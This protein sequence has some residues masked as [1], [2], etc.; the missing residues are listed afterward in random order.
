MARL[1]YFNVPA[2]GHINPS[3]PMVA[4]LVGRGEQVDYYCYE[5]FRPAIER[6]GARFRGYE[7]GF[8][9]EHV[10][11]DPNF[12]KFAAVLLKGVQ[13]LLPSLLP[14][15]E[16]ARPDYVIHDSLCSWGRYVAQ[17]LKL[18]D[19]CV[20]THFAMSPRVVGV[21]LKQVV[22]MGRMLASALP[23]VR[24]FRRV[25]REL[26]KAYGIPAP[27]ML[28]MYA[29]D[30]ER[31]LVLTSDYF[32]PLA[33]SFHGGYRFVGVTL[34]EQRAEE[35]LELPADR[36]IIYISLGTVFNQDLAFYRS[37]F[38]AFAGLDA[39]VVMSIGKKIAPGDLGPIPVNFTVR[40][41]VPQLA[42]L[43]RASLFIT[44]GGMNSV[45]EACWYGVPLIVVPQAADQDVVARRVPE[46]GAGL[47][48]RKDQL[49]VEALRAAV[50]TILASPSYG[51]ASKKLGQSRG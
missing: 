33:A 22:K 49:G 13:F 35:P 21:S 1:A 11:P 7:L 18:P 42:V 9:F 2:H 16:A 27:G 5:E 45:H 38:Q 44:H 20:T 10:G 25:G 17:I 48:L 23:D 19:I 12:F 43:R 50:D 15:V 32:Q 26:H 37:C 51:A 6:S 34:D 29:N 31:N 8:P 41:V 40:G 30:A 47:Q 4:E 28:E 36:P 46:L 39:H 3:L 24:E 14:A